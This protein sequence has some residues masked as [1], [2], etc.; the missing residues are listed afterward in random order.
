L[1]G[2]LISAK[3]ANNPLR[4]TRKASSQ[5]NSSGQAHQQHKSWTRRQECTEQK[6][7]LTLQDI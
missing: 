5:W 6:D 3:G 4:R 2:N 1:L 7:K